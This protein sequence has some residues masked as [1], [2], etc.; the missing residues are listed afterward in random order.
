MEN[1]AGSGRAGIG[2][3]FQSAKRLISHISRFTFHFSL[4]SP[5]KLRDIKFFI[6]KIDFVS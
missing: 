1:H 5:L 2:L 3:P 4:S 6:V